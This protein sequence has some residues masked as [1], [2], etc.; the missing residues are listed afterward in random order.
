MAPA[1]LMSESGRLAGRMALWIALGLLALAGG[2]Y[3]YQWWQHRR[4]LRMTR[5]DWLDDM[6]RTEGDPHVR[7]SR[8]RKAL[9]LSRRR[10]GERQQ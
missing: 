9:E 5:R 1:V 7:R 6:R 8:R 3:A 4:D 2:D 10:A